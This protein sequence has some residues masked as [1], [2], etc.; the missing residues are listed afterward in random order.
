M[1]P[2]LALLFFIFGPRTGFAADLD[3]RPEPEKKIEERTAGLLVRQPEAEQQWRKTLSQSPAEADQKALEAR[4]LAGQVIEH[5]RQQIPLLQSYVQDIWAR[6]KSEYVKKA[7][8]SQ[9]QAVDEEY[10]RRLVE[11]NREPDFYAQTHLYVFISES[12]PLVTLRNYMK[13]LNGAR[14]VFVLRGLVGDDPGQILP[15]QNWINSLL[16]GAPPYTKGSQC[17]LYPVDINPTL[18]R[19]FGVETVPALAYVREPTLLES[20]D[21]SELA[22][23]T[24][25]IWYGDMAPSYVLRQFILTW[26]DDAVLADL[27]AK[28]R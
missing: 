10:V 11:K 8:G 9:D 18:Y 16:C 19:L 7:S 17:Y 26:S 12:V 15:T 24:F 1:L 3:S 22:E 6:L 14:A 23:D 4:G 28:V 21:A 20:C 13:A 2:A 5:A 27:A 25:L